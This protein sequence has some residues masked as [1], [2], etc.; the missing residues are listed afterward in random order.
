MAD[1]AEDRDLVRF[2]KIVLNACRAD[3]GRRY[4]SAEELLTAVV[5]FQFSRY[6]PRK[7]KARSRLVKLVSAGGLLIAA[8]VI[9]LSVWRFIWLLNHEQ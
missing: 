2:N 1:T 5:S 3:A 4:Q 7:E 8:A 6:D 9:T